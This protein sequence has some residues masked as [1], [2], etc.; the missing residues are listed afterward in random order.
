MKRLPLFY[1]DVFAKENVGTDEEREDLK[2]QIK[3]I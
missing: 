3:C 2:K 1:S